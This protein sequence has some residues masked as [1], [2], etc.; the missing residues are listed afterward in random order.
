MEF[1]TWIHLY[2]WPALTML[3]VLI[4]FIVYLRYLPGNRLDAATAHV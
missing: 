4:V 3:D 1:F 2:L